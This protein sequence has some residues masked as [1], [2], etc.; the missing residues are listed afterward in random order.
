M[1][2]AITKLFAFDN[3]TIGLPKFEPNT[4]YIALKINRELF[5]ICETV[6]FWNKIV[7]VVLRITKWTGIVVTITIE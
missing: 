3:L 6:I 2:A 1:S 5:D 4:I 7:A